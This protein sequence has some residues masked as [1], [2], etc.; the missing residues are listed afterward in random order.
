MVHSP[1]QIKLSKITGF[2]NI[3][4]EKPVII[5]DF[6]GVIFYDTSPLK[7]QV[8]FFNM[9]EGIYNI[10]EGNIIK[11]KKPVK[12]KLSKLPAP[13]RNY[14]KPFDFNIVFGT[15]PNKCSIIWKKRTILFDNNLKNRTLPEIFFILYHEYG[16][17]LYH[18]EKYADLFSAN[19][20]KKKGFNDSQI[21]FSQ[22]NVL[23]GAQFHRK[24]FVI[25]NILKRQ[26]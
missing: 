11:L 3:T 16:H 4:P 25:N 20:M 1:K 10:V 9:P 21:G 6:R 15:N 13:E 26:K 24:K 14:P 5:T 2:K 12:I 8:S 17:Q 23:S 7:K 22:I 18:T 19:T